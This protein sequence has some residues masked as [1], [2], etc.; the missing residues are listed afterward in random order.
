MDHFNQALRTDNRDSA[1]HNGC[2]L[3]NRALAEAGGARGSLARERAIAHFRRSL[4]INPHQPQIR[5]MLEQLAVYEW[6]AVTVTEE[7]IP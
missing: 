6:K 4:Q 5:S 7:A 1:A 3:V 2:G